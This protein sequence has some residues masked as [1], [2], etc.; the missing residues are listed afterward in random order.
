MREALLAQWETGNGR[1]PLL[2]KRG[3][4][5]QQEA[6]GERREARDERRET[7]VLRTYSSGLLVRLGGLI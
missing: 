3:W 5:G 7:M 4:T 2:S 6:R 1:G